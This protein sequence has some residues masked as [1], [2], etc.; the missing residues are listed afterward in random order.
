MTEQPTPDQAGTWEI[1]LDQ[2]A[3]VI[4]DM[5]YETDRHVTKNNLALEPID[6]SDMAVVAVAEYRRQQAEQGMV[7]VRREDVQGAIAVLLGVAVSDETN[8]ESAYR[9][10]HDLQASLAAATERQ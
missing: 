10:M 7:E 1:D 6:A 9:L 5:Y 2:I 8:A 4:F 3:S